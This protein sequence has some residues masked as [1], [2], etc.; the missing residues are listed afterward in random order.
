MELRHLRY[1]LAVADA[2]SFTGAANALNLSQ[3]S[4]SVQIAAL[5]DEL[6]TALFDRLGR[7]LVLTQAG[8]LF[9]DH[10]RRV[11]RDLEQGVQ[12]VHELTGAE[13][14]RLLVGTLSTVNSYLIPPVV[15]R[16][17]RRFPK[18]HLQVHAQPSA[19]IETNLLANRLDIGLCLLPVSDSRLAATHL[20]DETLCL[21]APATFTRLG[22][23]AK[24]C[25]LASLPLVLMPA[26]YCLRRMVEA[27]CAEA[28]VR[29]QVSV[30]MTSPDGILDAVE[31]GAGLTVLPELFVRHR[32]RR[33]GL[34]MIELS[35]PVPTHGVGLVHLAHRHLG[36]AVEE[37][38]G[39]CRSVRSELA[40]TDR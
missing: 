29:P 24:M 8:H 32:L 21:V 12:E 20:F 36:V 11:L 35:G 3:P 39:L 17:R 15:S 1:F 6:G 25:E 2:M 4:L 27:E 37:F 31:Q 14:G 7:R 5:E 40:R 10:A 28:G 22:R 18:V 16:F 23:R 26:D 33:G 13:R 9:R 19:D 34:R 38:V 30:E